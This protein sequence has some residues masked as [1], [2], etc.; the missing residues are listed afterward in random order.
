M[1]K[2]EFGANWTFR[3]GGKRKALPL[4]KQMFD[5]NTYIFSKTVK[6]TDHLGVFKET[7]DINDLDQGE[8]VEEN[9]KNMEA[10]ERFDLF[11]VHGGIKYV[12]HNLTETFHKKYF[13]VHNLKFKNQFAR[14]DCRE[15]LIQNVGI[16]NEQGMAC[17]YSESL[18]SE[19]P[20]G[21]LKIGGDSIDQFITQIKSVTLERNA[22][23]IIDYLRVGPEISL[24]KII[25]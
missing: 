22:R 13:Q 7:D 5:E 10:A 11:A 3:A 4:L 25:E 15:K 21:I 6:E 2:Y 17:S 14:E 9:V 1:M 12:N 19:T 16:L 8:N 20:I 18:F 24:F 23:S